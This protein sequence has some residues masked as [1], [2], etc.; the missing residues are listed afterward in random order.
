MFLERQTD[1]LLCTQAHPSIPRMKKITISLIISH[2]LM[3][4]L[5]RP[6][7]K[8]TT[9]YYFQIVLFSAIDPLQ[10]GAHLTTGSD[11][12]TL[13][14]TKQTV[15][16]SFEEQRLIF[17]LIFHGKYSINL[18]FLFTTTNILCF[19]T[20]DFKVQLDSLLISHKVTLPKRTVTSHIG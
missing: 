7:K 19:P 16:L 3:W 1:C 11:V 20:G 5:F 15:C 8:S 9:V 14:C 10:L 18:I 2:L 4:V 6:S 17:I 13:L 12:G